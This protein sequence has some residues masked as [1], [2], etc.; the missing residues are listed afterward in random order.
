MK[1][2]E[3]NIDSLFII[4]SYPDQIF[5]KINDCTVIALG[6]SCSNTLSSDS[7]VEVLEQES[8]CTHK[9]QSLTLNKLSF[10]T[11]RK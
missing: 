1:L 10:G 2:S 11:V 5:K 9:K 7:E 6:Y 3:I 4:T 8:Y